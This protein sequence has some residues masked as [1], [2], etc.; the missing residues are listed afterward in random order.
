MDRHVIANKWGEAWGYDKRSFHSDQETLRF[1]KNH[2]KWKRIG[3]KS[4]LM[5]GCSYDLEHEK[6]SA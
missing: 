5:K 1:L 3:W 4:L 6:M 2:K